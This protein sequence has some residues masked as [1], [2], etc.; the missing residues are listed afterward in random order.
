MLEPQRRESRPSALPHAVSMY[1]Q[2]QETT[3]QR[4]PWFITSWSNPERDQTR[5]S[6]AI[7]D[8]PLY[9]RAVYTSQ[10]P[11]SAQA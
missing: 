1:A 5:P 11:R 9:P 8:E 7:Q 4:L 2:K 6:I 10:D 3:D